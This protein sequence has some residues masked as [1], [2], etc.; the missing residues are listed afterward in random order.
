M[1]TGSTQAGLPGQQQLQDGSIR[2]PDQRGS[3]MTKPRRRLVQ[4][5]LVWNQAAGAESLRRLR[6]LQRNWKRNEC[7]WPAQWRFTSIQ[8]GRKIAPPDRPARTN[9]HPDGGIMTQRIV[10]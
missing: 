1:P 3:H 5:Y 10:E 9:D 2:L 8:P 4:P 6:R 7:P